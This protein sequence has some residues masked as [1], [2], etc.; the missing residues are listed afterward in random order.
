MTK[1]NIREA[2]NQMD[3]DTDCKYDLVT[4]YESCNLTEEDK[5]D[6]AKSIADKE[7]ADVIYDKLVDKYGDDVSFDDDDINDLKFLDMSKDTYLYDEDNYDFEDLESGDNSDVD[8]SMK[9]FIRSYCDNCGKM[10]RV[11][12]EFKEF[13]KP[14]EDTIYT[15]SHCGA[16]NLLTAPH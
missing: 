14:F 4:L 16:K 12:V 9:G 8:E 3:K 6:I 7:D 15:C 5:K 10:N 11:E 2:L 1:V 13:N